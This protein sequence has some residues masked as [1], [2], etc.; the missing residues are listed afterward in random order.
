LGILLTFKIYIKTNNNKTNI[1]I[2]NL[3]WNSNK[4]IYEV[5]IYFFLTV[6]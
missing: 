3:I 1:L 2:F 4:N 6:K 5:V